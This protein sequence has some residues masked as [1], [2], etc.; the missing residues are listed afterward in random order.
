MKI[1]A[2]FVLSIAFLLDGTAAPSGYPPAADED[3]L[4]IS[5]AEPENGDGYNAEEISIQNNVALREFYLKRYTLIFR[6]EMLYGGP[7]EFYINS[8]FRDPKSGRYNSGQRIFRDNYIARQIENFSAELRA[9]LER[10]G[11]ARLILQGA[12]ESDSINGGEDAQ[13]ITQLKN[14]LAEISSAAS[15]LGKIL[16]PVLPTLP[17]SLEIEPGEEIR[18][19]E[20]SK[21]LQ[22]LAGMID[23][24][25]LIIRDYFYS[26]RHAVSVEQLSKGDICKQL[27]RIETGA[28]ILREV[29][30]DGVE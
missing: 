24:S 17:D 28:N 21:S 29:L 23:G 15:V 5:A 18:P 6:G 8:D 10:L 16:D 20:F 22:A 30:E 13:D 1:T 25:V 14:A 9:S 4:Q 11:R 27:K 19:E 2:V 12:E 3:P 7:A 26:P